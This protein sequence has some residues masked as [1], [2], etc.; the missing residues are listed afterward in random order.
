MAAWPRPTTDSESALASRRLPPTR[1]YEIL[2]AGFERR[3]EHVILLLHAGIVPGHH[4]HALNAGERL[5]QHWAVGQFRD[6]GFGIRTQHFGPLPGDSSSTI[7]LRH[8]DA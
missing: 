3:V 4:E 6:R 2:G 8:L 5:F 1:T 7:T